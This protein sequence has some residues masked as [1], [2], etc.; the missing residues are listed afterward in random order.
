MPDGVDRPHRRDPRRVT[1]NQG[2][3]QRD[4][5]ASI[6]PSVLSEEP[7]RGAGHRRAIDRLGGEAPRDRV[8]ETTRV[9]LRGSPGSG[10]PCTTTPIPSALCPCL[11]RPPPARP[12]QG[13]RA[14][15]AAASAKAAPSP[16]SALFRDLGERPARRSK[17]EPE[18]PLSL[19]DSSA[20][21]HDRLVPRD[22]GAIELRADRLGARRDRGVLE[23][24]R[25]GRAER[26]GCFASPAETHGRRDPRL[27]HRV[28]IRRAERPP[29]RQVGRVARIARSTRDHPPSGERCAVHLGL[30]LAR[31]LLPRE[32]DRGR[33]PRGRVAREIARREVERDDEAP[34]SGVRRRRH[35]LELGRRVEPSQSS[36]ERPTPRPPSA[37]AARTASSAVCARAVSVTRAPPE[38]TSP[39]ASYAR[40]ASPDKA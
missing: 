33:D 24:P 10:G 37:S 30:E 27:A 6:L 19:F 32:R 7:R 11:R 34:S 5:R 4:Q 29:G 35:L 18:I 2:I 12:Q 22:D 3:R 8:C 28:G 17:R 21:L 26:R 40:A 13:R 36:R 38:G 15:S 1:R 39:V 23:H 14:R 20:H 16:A 25:G 31:D 9:S